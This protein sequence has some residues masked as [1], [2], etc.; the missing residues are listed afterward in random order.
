MQFRRL[1]QV[2]VVIVM[3]FGV[4]GSVQHAQ[5]QVEQPAL[6]M[7]INPT[8][9]E[10][11]ETAAVSIGL[12]NVPAEGYTSGE[13]TC[14]Y[15]AT[16][17]EVSD[18]VVADLFGTDPATA[19]N[20]PQA[21]T[22]IVAVAGSNGNKAT[23]DGTV[24]TFS[25]KGL[26]FG[27]NTIECSARVSLGNDTLS[28][29]PPAD[30]TLTVLASPPP[31]D[32]LTFTNLTYGF[33]F[34]YPPEGQIAEGR[35]D[36]F[37]RIDLPFQ[38]GTNLR[39]KYLEVVVE[40]GVDPCQSPLASQPMLQTPETITING[41]SF[42]K[43]TGEDGGAG[44][45]H[46]WIAYSTSMNNAC[47]S[48]DFI[49]HSLNPGNFETPPPVFDYDLEAAVFGQIVSTFEWLPS[50]L[51]GTLS[52]QVNASKVVTITLYDAD[53]APVTSTSVDPD[54]TFSLTAPAGDY[55]AIATASGFLSA[56]GH[57]VLVSGITTTKA[58]INLPAGDID[59]NNVIDQ[60]D[61]MTIGM[62]YNTALPEAADLNNDGIINV[63]DLE[64]LA[65]NYRASGSVLWQ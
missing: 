47:V 28:E 16:K 38:E 31:D 55:T 23:I 42:L 14:T 59:S 36:D 8:S 50:Q 3:L 27:S 25:A 41:I 24:F 56:Q 33:Q 10:V 46:Q 2:F 19:I 39:E 61:A 64:A 53:S 60:F 26:Q 49:L 32:W 40:E 17:I 65:Q 5:A 9:V 54:G 35:T 11:G 1:T 18:I 21:G 6:S 29:L 34:K 13:F 58:T 12:D 52:G 22:F 30:G 20:G 57:V 51:D 7:V 37:A 43:Q 45:L 4:L 15:D 63:L 48:L 62:N 44:H